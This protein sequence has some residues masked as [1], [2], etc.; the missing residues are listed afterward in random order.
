MSLY[1]NIKKNYG[2]FALDVKFEQDSGV[3]GLLGASGCGKTLTLRAISGIITPDSGKI[4]LNGKTLYDSEKRVHIPPQKRRTGYLFQ[5]YALFPNMTTKQNIACGLHYIRDK[6]VRNKAVCDMINK[7]QLTGLENLK[8]NQLSGGQQQRVALARILAGEPE[9]L[10]L[11]EPF[12]ALDSYLKEQMLLELRGILASFNKDT[13]IVT[14]SRDEAYKLCENLA[15]MENGIICDS[16]GAKAI[17]S[18]PQTITSAVLT[19]CKNIVAAE[20]CGETLVRVSTWGV[21]FETGRKIG[22]NPIAIGIRSHHFSGDAAENTYPVRVIETIEEPFEWTVKFRYENQ[23]DDGK[24]IIMQ[25]PKE[26]SAELPSSIGVIANDIHL[27]YERSKSY[28][29]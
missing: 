26:V 27:L 1:V 9:I 19:G 14:H 22:E 2:S 3:L 6:R 5:N 7:M 24:A 8:P 29:Y 12:S 11:D 21:T 25:F 10:L 23:T 18:N 13:L 17:F 28:E 20:K 4:V 16:G 15:I